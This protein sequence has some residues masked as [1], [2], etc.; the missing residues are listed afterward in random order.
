M[1]LYKKI[2]IE[3]TASIFVFLYALFFG[4]K[5]IYLSNGSV[6][7]HYPFISPDGYDW[8]VEGMYLVRYLS[9]YSLPDLFVLR[10]PIF[11][12]IN[13]VDYIFGGAGLILG[14]V[15]A[16]SIF[17]SYWATI[18]IVKNSSVLGS[19]LGLYAFIVA[20]VY[21]VYPLNF[22]KVYLL[23]DSVAIMLS[24]L[25]IYYLFHPNKNRNHI[26]AA[27]VAVIAGLTQTYA[28]LPYLISVTFIVFS[29]K[30]F[31]QFSLKKFVVLIIVPLFIFF[32]MTIAWRNFLSHE[33]TPNNF[34]LLK[35]NFDMFNFYKS[36]WGIYLLPF[37]FI[38][39]LCR[40][41]VLRLIKSRAGLVC[42][43][44]FIVFAI[45]CFFYQWQE[46]RFTYYLMPWV[47]IAVGIAMSSA[48]Q[49]LLKFGIIVLF[50]YTVVTPKNYWMPDYSNLTMSIE[51]NWVASF[52]KAH[53]TNR[54]L[55]NCTKACE[56]TNSTILNGDEYVKKTLVI[57][58]SL[59]S[60]P[61][62]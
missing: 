59:N 35:F 46:A 49:N 25:S 17:I 18:Q 13:A 7:D 3:S 39:V 2:H 36:T 47:L 27:T 5:F 43:V 58:L 9:G 21:T 20:I 53:S 12:L 40:F 10:P 48:N 6:I 52:F 57:Y 14:F 41:S 22:F 30:S 55:S 16:A 34:N 60:L 8:Q 45:F 19:N 37:A 61:P 50:V 1:P 56:L 54:N 4:L 51:K 42:I 29:L 28:L 24:L 33:M 62:K 23:G 44:N 32:V 15:Y 31:N 11:V 26:K 38:A